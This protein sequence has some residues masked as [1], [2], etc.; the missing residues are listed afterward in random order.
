MRVNLMGLTHRPVRRRALSLF[1]RMVWP[2]PEDRWGLDMLFLIVAVGVGGWVG[3]V[4]GRKVLGAGIA[5]LVL[6]LREAVFH[7]FVRRRR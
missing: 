5:V 2:P 4:E 6:A 1:R 7:V 3:R